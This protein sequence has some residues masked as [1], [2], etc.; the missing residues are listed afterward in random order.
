MNSRSLWG[1]SWWGP[2]PNQLTSEKSSANNIIVVVKFIIK[3]LMHVPG[4]KDYHACRILTVL[5]IHSGKRERSPNRTEAKQKF[6]KIFWSSLKVHKNGWSFYQWQGNFFT[7]IADDEHRPIV[8]TVRRWLSEVSDLNKVLM[9]CLKLLG[10]Q[11][12]LVCVRIT[13]WRNRQSAGTRTGL[14]IRSMALTTDKTA[15]N[16]G[17]IPFWWIDARA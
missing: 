2:R 15:Q 11:L 17:H 4:K 5:I 6:E 8:K 14:I 13:G 3:R 12:H 7:V 1:D 16:V 9:V 10:C